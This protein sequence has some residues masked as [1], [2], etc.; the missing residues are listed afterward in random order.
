MSQH[1]KPWPGGQSARK[2]SSK[3][4]LPA[5]DGKAASDGDTLHVSQAIRLVSCDTPESHYPS[6]SSAKAAQSKLDTCRKRL[7]NGDFDAHLPKKLR[8]YLLKRLTK[9]AGQEQ[10]DGANLA[11][12]AF[13]RML[14][15]R[16]VNAATKKKR[17]LGVLPAGEVIDSYGRMLAYLT[18]WYDT[19]KEKLPPKDDPDRRTFNLQ[20]V[21]EGWAAFFPIHGSLPST[22]AD[23]DLALKAARLAWK[24][25]RGVWKHYGANYLLGYEF[26]MCVKLGMPYKAKTA[27]SAAVTAKTL[28]TGAFQRVCIDATGAKWKEVGLHGFWEV[29][30][31]NRLWVWND[32]IATA[33]KQLPL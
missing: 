8:D 5:A 7:E 14:A 15:K 6:A 16:L 30:P 19:K 17:G 26:R 27:T 1:T 28:C 3:K 18:P 11:H 29:E 21:E 31:P 22:R 4:L 32:D 20:M 13:E 10:I 23:F 9:N 25:K 24:K 2:S 33:R 12:D